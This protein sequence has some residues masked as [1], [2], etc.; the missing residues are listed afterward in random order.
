MFIVVVAVVPVLSSLANTLYILW[1]VGAY[2]CCLAV[3][4]SCCARMRL[5]YA[6][7]MNI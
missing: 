7:T 4:R 2:P 1:E 5:V 3:L 6:A